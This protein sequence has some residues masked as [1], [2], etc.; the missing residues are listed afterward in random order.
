[1]SSTTIF[2]GEI[3]YIAQK[4]SKNCLFFCEFFEQMQQNFVFFVFLFEN[5]F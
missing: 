3:L 1:M 5:L 2:Q 4:V